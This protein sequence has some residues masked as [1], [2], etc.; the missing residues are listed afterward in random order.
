MS[1]LVLR[2]S[3]VPANFQHQIE[4]AKAYAGS[5]LLPGHLRGKPENVLV[6]LGA[7][8]ALDIPAFWAFQSLFVVGGKLGMEA[9]L[10]RALVIRAGH[11]FETRAMTRDKAIVAIKRSDKSSWFEVEFDMTDA[12][13][14]KLSGE[15]WTKYPR[16]MLHAR[17]TVMAIRA[18]CPEVLY[19]ILYTPEELGAKVDEEG[20]P[21][22]DNQ[23]GMVILDST[24]EEVAMVDPDTLDQWAADLCHDNLVVGATAYRLMRTAGVAVAPENVSRL[25]ALWT[26]RLV[27]EL[28]REDATPDELR[29]LWKHANYTDQL[30]YVVDAETEQTLRHAIASRVASLV[31]AEAS[32]TDE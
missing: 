13:I 25:T 2:P 15:N 21:V 10:M 32:S 16:S 9:S 1:E 12:K 7:A 30:E 20:H 31:D 28:E 26:A 24:A 3:D 27:D 4:M 19:G 14:A 8:K 17:A 11:Q 18:E 6:V 29:T 23:N 22:L 5:S